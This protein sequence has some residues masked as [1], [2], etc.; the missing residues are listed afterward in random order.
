MTFGDDLAIGFRN[1]FIVIGFVCVFVG[2][3]VRESGV[4]SR[5]LGMALIVVGAF[6]IATATLGRLLGWW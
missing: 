2:L 6:L 4:T 5:G 3:L 1:A